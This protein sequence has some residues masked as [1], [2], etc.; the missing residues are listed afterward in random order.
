MLPS[1]SVDLQELKD[2]PQLV[3][4][5]HFIGICCWHCGHFLKP[6]GSGFNSTSPAIMRSALKTVIIRINGFIL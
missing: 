2:N 4:V 6:R 5:L 1:A 3:H